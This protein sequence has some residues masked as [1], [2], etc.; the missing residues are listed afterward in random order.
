[1]LVMVSALRAEGI[2]LNANPSPKSILPV[3]PFTG[4][5]RLVVQGIT[6]YVLIYSLRRTHCPVVK[7]FWHAGVVAVVHKV[8]DLAT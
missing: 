2:T 3:G 8:V 7:F 4:S 5:N 1:M 6:R